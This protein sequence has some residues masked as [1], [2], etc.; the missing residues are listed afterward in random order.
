MQ[1]QNLN[2]DWAIKF[3][4]FSKK[5]RNMLD[6]FNETEFLTEVAIKKTEMAI[7]DESELRAIYKSFKAFEEV[8]EIFFGLD[9]ID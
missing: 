5:R 6:F 4:E 2:Q 7:T 8:K 9:R 1:N 3:G